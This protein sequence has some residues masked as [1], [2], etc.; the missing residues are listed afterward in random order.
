MGMDAQAVHKATKMPMDK[1]EALRRQR[2][3][4]KAPA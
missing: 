3:G 4:S 1:V 2:A